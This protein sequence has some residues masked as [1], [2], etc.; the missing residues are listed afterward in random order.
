MKKYMITSEE[1]ELMCD[2]LHSLENENNK[3]KGYIEGFE[4]QLTLTDVSDSV[5]SCGTKLVIADPQILRCPNYECE[6]IETN[7]R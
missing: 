7:E 2:K 5:C 6:N 1:Y 3:L 4:K